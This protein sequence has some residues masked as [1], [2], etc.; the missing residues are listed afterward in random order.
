MIIIVCTDDESLVRIA[1]KTSQSNPSV[2]GKYYKAFKD[3]IPVIGSQENLFIIAHGAYHGDDGNPVIGDETNAFYVNAVDFYKNIKGI[4]PDGYSGN[5]YID[6]CESAD[7][8]EE[9]F[10]FTEVF[11][12]QIQRDHGNTEIFGRNGCIS[13]MIPLPGDSRWKRASV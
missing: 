10:S 13:G 5:V 8:E 7:H 1:Q 6:A 3:K 9:T 12:A 2:Y 4:F 11:K